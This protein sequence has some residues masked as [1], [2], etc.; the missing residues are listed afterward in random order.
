MDRI[1]NF[2]DVDKSSL[3]LVGGKNA[4][5]GEM[6]KAGVRVPP[7]FAVTTVSYLS[8][9]TETG[10]KEKIFKILSDIKPEDV[11]SLN[12]AS[13]ASQGRTTLGQCPRARNPV[14]KEG[15]DDAHGSAISSNP[16]PD[17]RETC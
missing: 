12:K 1:L 7:G 13:A 5:L 11:E 15:P 10:I 17:A 2:E 8:F 9:I 6:I 3:Q 4:S 14:R 16:T